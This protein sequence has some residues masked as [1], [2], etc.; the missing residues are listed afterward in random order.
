MNT[1]DIVSAVAKRFGDFTRSYEMQTL[2]PHVQRQAI[3]LSGR[4]VSTKPQSQ[5]W[6]E[7]EEERNMMS[8]EARAAEIDAIVRRRESVEVGAKL[9]LAITEDELKAIVEEIDQCQQQ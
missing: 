6:R 9:A 4:T 3:E 2:P 7:W 5:V 8:M 1:N